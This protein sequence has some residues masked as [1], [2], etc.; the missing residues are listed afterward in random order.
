MNESA[1]F[2]DM[3]SD[4]HFYRVLGVL[5]RTRARRALQC[6]SSQE[7]TAAVLQPRHRAVA[8]RRCAAGLRPHL[9]LARSP[10]DDPRP[11]MAQKHRRYIRTVAVFKEVRAC[12]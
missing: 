9:L 2:E 8:P 6:H 7:A 1:I 5:E 3:V 10:A 4:A 11:G 12:A